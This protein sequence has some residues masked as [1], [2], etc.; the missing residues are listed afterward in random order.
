MRSHLHYH[1]ELPADVQYSSVLSPLY[2]FVTSALDSTLP[3]LFAMIAFSRARYRSRSWRSLA[4]A[5]A[6]TRARLRSR[7]LSVALAGARALGARAL[8]ARALGAR[9]RSRTL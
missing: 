1:L 8:G 3:S 7:A 6:L 4:L 5:Q 2:S 9:L